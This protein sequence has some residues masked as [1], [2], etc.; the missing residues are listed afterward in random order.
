M[1]RK[2][3]SFIV[4]DAPTAKRRKY[5]TP[6][7]R[8]YRK[9]RGPYGRGYQPT[10]ASQPGPEL[11]WWDHG[12][13]L[14]ALDTAPSGANPAL[15]HV[16]SLN[17]MAA[18]DDGDQ[19]NGLKIQAKKINLRFRCHTDANSDGVNANIVA[20]AHQWRVVLYVD[21]APN[22]A[23]P[24]WDQ[25]IQVTPNNEAQQ[26]AYNKLASTGRFKILMDKWITVPPSYV[27]YDGTNYHAYG[28]NK[29]FKKSIPL[30]MAIH[31]SDTTN[32]LAAIQRNN[33]GMFITSDGSAT[34]YTQMKFS[35]RARLR[36][37]DY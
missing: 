16:L 6:Y 24:T 18:G 20:D 28:N 31:Y 21:T 33:I 17:Q 27:V 11:K 2:R 32:N 7:K 15:Y 5:D 4:E 37:V 9:K 25:L 10:S 29:F 12:A 14:T 36:F 22:G 3:A 34:S 8:P 13:N 19:R 23:A 1:L 35:Y 30:D 26:F